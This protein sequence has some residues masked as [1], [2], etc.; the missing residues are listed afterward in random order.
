MKPL[1]T[2]LLLLLCACCWCPAEE[3]EADPSVEC[4]T[5]LEAWRKPDAEHDDQTRTDLIEAAIRAERPEV[6]EEVAAGGD[7]SALEIQPSADTKDIAVSIVRDLGEVENGVFRRMTKNRFEAWSSAHGWLF[8]AKGKLLGEA[9]PPRR[10]GTGREWYGAFLPDGRWVTTDLW[11]YDR[12]LT[13]FSREGKW[14]QEIPSEQLAPPKEARDGNGHDLIGWARC[15]RNGEGWVVSIGPRDGRAR[16]FVTPNGKTR[17]MEGSLPGENDTQSKP[18]AEPWKLCY[19]RDLEPKGYYIALY[20][21]SDDYLSQISMNRPGHGLWSGFPVYEWGKESKTIIPNGGHNFGFLP[22]THAVYISTDWF[23][24]KENK[25]WFF[26]A[27]GKCRGWARGAYLTDSADEKA[28]W[29]LN[30]GNEVVSLGLD[31][32]PRARMR[33]TLRGASAK[34]V[35]LFPGLRLGFFALDKKM[36]LARW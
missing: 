2:G 30:Q 14:L 32:K 11:E 17:L 33:F 23:D 25:T 29:L 20:R 5:R 9:L 21:P 13:F 4:T 22:G 16:V 36:I 34:P 26:G 27:E 24:Q 28:I 19:P 15:D 10:D 7:P 35:K 6:I 3:E 8:N 18:W 12:T 1:C 31:L